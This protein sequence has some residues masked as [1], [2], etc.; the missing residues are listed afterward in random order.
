MITNPFASLAASLTDK[1][2]TCALGGPAKCKRHH[3]LYDP[4]AQLRWGQDDLVPGYADSPDGLADARD[5]RKA[6]AR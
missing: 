4:L 2:C 5:Q 6:D 3:H 1:P